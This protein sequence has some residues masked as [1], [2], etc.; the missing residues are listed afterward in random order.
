M[1]VFQLAKEKLAQAPVLV[2]YDPSLSLVM[3]ADVSAYGLGAVLSHCFPDGTERPNEYASRTLS[4]S[5]C[6]YAQVEKEAL[7]LVFGI[8]KFH[9]YL[10]GRRFVLITDHKPLLAILGPKQGIPLL[11]AAWM[12]RWALLLATY[13]YEIEFR[14]TAKHSN[15][16]ALSRLPL[17]GTTPVG[18][19]HDAT[20][21]H[22][23]QLDSLPVS[24]REIAVATQMINHLRRGWPNSIPNSLKPYW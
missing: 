1:T 15:A 6:N 24:G 10:Y 2:H 23:Q 4:S 17:P 7:E 5:E 11:A 22:F 9:Q 21:L 12:Q 18:N 14:S 20:I 16:D 13:S 19:P 3:A 8:K